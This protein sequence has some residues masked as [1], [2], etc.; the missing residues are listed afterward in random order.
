PC[1]RF[2]RRRPSW[3]RDRPHAGAATRASPEPTMTSPVPPVSAAVRP[4]PA[5]VS[6]RR[7]G[8]L[9]LCSLASLALVSA[10]PAQTAVEP[11]DDDEQDAD[12]VVLSPFTVDASQDKGYRA[13]S[14]LAGSR[15]NTSLRD[16]ASS[17]SVV[18]SEFLR[19]TAAV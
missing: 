11:T 1:V 17:I 12:A 6:F 10:L 4:R 18:T 16:V 14:T 19:D 3:R 2:A 15:I 9:A 8:L 7:G 5:T 13:T